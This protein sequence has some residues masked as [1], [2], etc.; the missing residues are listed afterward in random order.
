MFGSFNKHPN[1]F[2]EKSKWV[3][4]PNSLWKSSE[5]ILLLSVYVHNPLPFPGALLKFRKWRMNPARKMG[6]LESLFR[7]VVP[8]TEGIP[9]IHGIKGDST[10]ITDLVI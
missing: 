3:N 10:W 5:F 9:N 6:V 7:R 1:K 8:S 4:R 2:L